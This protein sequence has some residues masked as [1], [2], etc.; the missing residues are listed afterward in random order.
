MDVFWFWLWFWLKHRC[1]LWLWLRFRLRS[2][3]RLDYK[4]VF[5]IFSTYDSY[6]D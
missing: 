4:L 5:V 2:N 1:R 6:C 3:D